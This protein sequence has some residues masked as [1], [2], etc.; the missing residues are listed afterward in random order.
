MSDSIE[1]KI[2]EKIKIGTDI[3]ITD[4]GNQ[5]GYTVDEER[6]YQQLV[7]D[8]QSNS[9]ITREPVYIAAGMSRDG[10]DD[11]QGTYIEINLS[12]QHLWFYKNFQL[13]YLN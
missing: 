12:L 5:Y 11:L 3:T 8:I 7:L 9:K 1:R 6:E 2:D 4:T 10:M 13:F